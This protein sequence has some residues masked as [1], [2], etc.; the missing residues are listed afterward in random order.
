MLDRGDGGGVEVVRAV[1]HAVAAVGLR[2]ENRFLDEA[3]GAVAGNDPLDQFEVV[4]DVVGVEVGQAGARP[5]A[6]SGT[7]TR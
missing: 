3:A 2:A 5:V 4:V 1:D 6:L 7:P